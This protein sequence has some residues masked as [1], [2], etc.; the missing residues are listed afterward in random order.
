MCDFSGRRHRL[1]PSMIPRSPS[2]TLMATRRE[3]KP[4]LSSRSSRSSEV[5]QRRKTDGS[6]SDYRPVVPASPPDD[7]DNSVERKKRKKKDKKHK[8]DKKNKKKKKRSKQHSRS[9]SSDSVDNDS[10]GASTPKKGSKD[11]EKDALS[12]WEESQKKQIL[13]QENNKIDTSACSPVSNDSHIASPEPM[14]IERSPIPTTPPLRTLHYPP[15]ESPHTPPLLPRALNS[16][17][18]YESRHNPYSCSPIIAID[19]YSQSHSSIKSPYRNP[20]PDLVAIHHSHTSSLKRRRLDKGSGH[21]KHRRDKE[22]LREKRRSSRSP[23]RRRSR[24]PSWSRRHYDTSPGR[25]KMKRYRSRS[26]RREREK[27]IT[28]LV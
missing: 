4:S 8:K 25:G 21:R 15:R 11:A 28:R 10:D 9:T 24:S 2:P 18:D 27:S 19:D 22:K 26:P 23:G 6:P 5:R 13:S 7:Y 16:V 12:D 17:D 1:D 20:S 14:D 3:R